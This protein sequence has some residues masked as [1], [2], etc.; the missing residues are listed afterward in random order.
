MS[1]RCHFVSIVFSLGFRYNLPYIFLQVTNVV[2][3]R[4]THQKTAVV[5][6]SLLLDAYEE[7]NP[8]HDL[9]L[10]EWIESTSAKSPTFYFWILVLSLISLMLS[11]VRSLRQGNYDLFLRCIADMLPWYFLFDHQHYSRW[12]TVQLKDLLELGCKAPDI[13]R[14]FKS[15]MTF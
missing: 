11:F 1:Y 13:H 15:G 6:Y 10:Q 3:A 8:D 2:R 12:L 4:V 14:H 9:T 7:H 5:L